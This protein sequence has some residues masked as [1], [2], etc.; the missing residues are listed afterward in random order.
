VAPTGWA[1]DEVRLLIHGRIVPRLEEL[2]HLLGGPGDDRTITSEHD[3]ALHELGMRQQHLDDRLG[4]LV[5]A[6]VETELCKSP[7]VANQRRRWIGDRREDPLQARSVGWTSRYSMTSNSTPRS[8]RIS[9]APRDLPQ[10]GLCNTV[11]S[12][13]LRH[14][15]LVSSSRLSRSDP[16]PDIRSM[17]AVRSLDPGVPTVPPPPTPLGRRG[18]AGL[19]I[20][21]L[22]LAGLAGTAGPGGAD[23]IQDA[24]AAVQA[25]RRDADAAAAAY[26][27]ALEQAQATDRQ[28]ADL[29][30]QL[31]DLVARVQSVQAEVRRRAAAAYVRAASSHQLSTLL[32]GGDA[33]TVARRVHLLDTFN[34]RDDTSLR[35]LVKLQA[36]LQ[37]Q[38]DTLTKARATQQAALDVLDARG[39]DIN[40]KLQAALDQSRALHA[41][42]IPRPVVP[43]G[44]GP[45]TKPTSPPPSPPTDYHPN[46]SV[47]P[48]HDDPFL[49]C[50]RG[51]ES[52]GNY[53]AYNPAGPYLGAY[54][55]LQSTWNSAANHAGRV[56][57]IG[58]PANTASAYDQDDVAWALYQWKGPAPWGGSCA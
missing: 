31:P 20:L 6:R 10:R 53:A 57:L 19:V 14:A 54:Q 3:G 16:T 2:E 22:A 38:R 37:S 48:H 39:R 29:A 27:A 36:A 46:P 11:T 40:A 58:V 12:L 17:S 44:A 51:I 30:R 28:I 26:F 35:E 41:A 43:T 45:G 9:T 18:C 5:G 8:V 23:P 55:F 56:D 32:S 42:V 7:V 13:T 15:T 21:A 24:D 1:H 52:G 33:L 25:L 4:R 34:A 50:T 49:S 47:N